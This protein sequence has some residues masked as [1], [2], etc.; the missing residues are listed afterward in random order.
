M[1]IE[2]FMINNIKIHNKFSSFMKKNSTKTVVIISTGVL[3]A[4]IIINYGVNSKTK[5]HFDFMPPPVK[6]EERIE[7]QE[8]V[9]DPNHI[10]Y[11]IKVALHQIIRLEPLS[12]SKFVG[13]IEENSDNVELLYIDDNYALI[14]YE[15]KNG[16]IK[17]GYIEKNSIANLDKV[18]T[19]YQATPSNMYGEIINNGCRLQ[20]EAYEDSSEFNILTRC[21]QGEFVK[22]IGEINEYN[23]K[24]YIVNYRDY[25]GYMNPINLRVMT[26]A[27]FLNVTNTNYI[28]I[29]GNKVRFRKEPEINKTNIITEFDK[30]MKLPIISK[31]KDWFYVYYNGNYGYVSTRNDCSKEIYENYQAPGLTNIHL[32]SQETKGI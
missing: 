22:I 24:W 25:I 7:T 19:I 32:D 1:I 20:N 13:K 17:I 28:V 21:K 29:V 11:R 4:G 31:T 27:E 15:D 23:Q 9:Y 3:L 14:S 26:K 5:E 10:T 30:G 6:V 8:E 12:D 2:V 16:N 18:G